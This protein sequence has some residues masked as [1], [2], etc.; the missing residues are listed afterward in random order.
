MG[1]V[2][3]LTF[4]GCDE[5]SAPVRG[6]RGRS[7]P[8]LRDALQQEGRAGGQDFAARGADRAEGRDAF[9]ATAQVHPD[10]RTPGRAFPGADL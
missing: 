4:G 1:L 8:D 2:A 9:G 5:T 6:H 10:V 7:T 3:A